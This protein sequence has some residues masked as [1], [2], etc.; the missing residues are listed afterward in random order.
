MAPTIEERTAARLLDIDVDTDAAGVQ[1]AFR[2]MAKTVHPDRSV[3]DGCVD[4]GRLAEA[5][6]RLLERRA[7]HRAQV[8]ADNE[9][10]RSLVKAPPKTLFDD[11]LID[12]TSPLGHLVDVTG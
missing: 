1:A 12:L 11:H 8:E 4:I 9:R 5:R 10:R 2:T 3:A 7:R 6:D